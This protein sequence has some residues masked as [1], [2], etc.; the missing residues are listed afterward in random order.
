VKV[1]FSPSK[2]A[3]KPVIESRELT[4]DA[5]EALIERE[6]SIR[7]FL[8]ELTAYGQIHKSVD[9]DLQLLMRQYVAARNSRNS[10]GVEHFTDKICE[11]VIRQYY[12]EI[13]V[14]FPD[15]TKVH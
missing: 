5:R 11:R 7:E 10:K 14:A 15:F 8:E 9:E 1:F 4:P 13:G 3:A 2:A 6:D 12:A